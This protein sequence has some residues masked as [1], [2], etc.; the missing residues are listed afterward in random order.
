MSGLQHSTDLFGLLLL[1]FDVVSPHH[2]CF[3][4]L[5]VRV[6]RGGLQLHE[7]D[8]APH[9]LRQQPT[10]PC[11]HLQCAQAVLCRLL[12]LMGA[13]PPAHMRTHTHIH[14]CTLVFGLVLFAAIDTALHLL[15]VSVVFPQF[16][17]VIDAR[18]NRV[19]ARIAPPLR[20]LLPRR[21]HTHI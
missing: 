16:E 17:V 12:A 2:D 4:L 3:G 21:P 11:A 13:K 9:R 10:V 1:V 6:M 19:T 18:A 5:S 15:A 14:I 7:I 20:V 8:F